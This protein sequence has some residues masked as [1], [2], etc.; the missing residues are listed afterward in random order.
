M[1]LGNL[2]SRLTLGVIVVLTAVIVAGGLIV[3]RDVDRAERG[4]L[5]DRLRR[6]AELTDTTALAAVDNAVPERDRR[7]DQV[8]RATGSGIYVSVGGVI[9][10]DAGVR[11]DGLEPGAELRTPL[12]FS[13]M[14]VGGER[15][16][17]FT[18]TLRADDLGS[19][20]RLQVTTSLQPVSDRR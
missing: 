19:L 11:R 15:I 20:S 10:Y 9:S 2:R 14:E 7:L 4:N 1:R 13:D 12:G 18:K 16:R 6:T 5:D 8:L 3:A 17:V